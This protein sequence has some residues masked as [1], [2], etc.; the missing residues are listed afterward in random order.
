MVNPEIYGNRYNRNNVKITGK[1]R[2]VNN[3]GLFAIDL[4][5]EINKFIG[6]MILTP[7]HFPPLTLAEVSKKST[8]LCSSL[9]VPLDSPREGV[10][11]IELFFNRYLFK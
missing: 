8:K 5:S 7:F 10:Q 1:R 2:A 4:I 9:C 6:L 11:L 3:T